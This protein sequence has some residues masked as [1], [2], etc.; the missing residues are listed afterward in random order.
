MNKFNLILDLDETII[1]SVQFKS[2]KKKNGQHS[3]KHKKF[4]MDDDYIV[5][6]RPYLDEFLDFIF[7]NFNVSIWTAACKQYSIHI[8]NKIMN[9]KKLDYV[10]FEDHVSMA[11]KTTNCLKKLDILWDVYKLPN[12]HQQNTFILDDNSDVYTCQPSNCLK[13]PMFN[14][15]SND[16]SFLLHLISQLKKLTTIT[17]IHEMNVANDTI[18]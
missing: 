3:D 10:F 14:Y 1:H 2:F 12:Y 17:Q 8:I 6:Y 11:S 5:H 7:E 18:K 9:T 13:I 15:K 4:Q 16:D